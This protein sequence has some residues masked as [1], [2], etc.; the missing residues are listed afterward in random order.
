M[1]AGAMIVTLK[2]VLWAT[3]GIVGKRMAA[4]AKILFA[5]VLHTRSASIN[6]VVV[7]LLPQQIR[8]RS[9]GNQHGSVRFVAIHA[10]EDV[11]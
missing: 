8:G 5:E 2:T 6:D 10:G 9:F 4:F 3:A 7:D 1:A 11:I